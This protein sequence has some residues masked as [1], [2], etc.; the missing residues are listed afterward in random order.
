MKLINGT[1]R[2]ECSDFV[3]GA[4]YRSGIVTRSA[5]ILYWMRGKPISD[6]LKRIRQ[7]RPD[8]IV[9]VKNAVYFP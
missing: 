7:F 9:Y 3:A 1:I 6:C 2:I 4:D 8:A 5:P